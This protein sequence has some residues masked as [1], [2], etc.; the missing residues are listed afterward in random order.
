MKAEKKVSHSKEEDAILI[1]QLEGRPR[2]RTAVPL[3]LQ[4]VLAM[5]TGNLAPILIIASAC[6]L[7]DGDIVIMMQSAMFVSG[8]TTFVQLYPIRIGKHFRIG[9]NLPIV[10]GT[11][12]AFVPTATSVAA[13][14][15]I[16]AVLAGSIV[17]SL[18][19]VII[20]FF[21]KWVRHLFPPLVIGCTLVTIGIDLL[22]VGANY[23]A[24]GAGAADYGSPQNIAI[25]T[26][27]L[28]VIVLLQ[29]F[30]KGL[31]KSTSIL[32]GLIVGYLISLALN[33]VDVQSIAEASFFSV[34][35][36]LYFE[37]DFSVAAIV[38]FIPL[39]VFSGIDTIGST[40]GVAMA[41][42]D[43]EATA[44]E[45]SGAILADALG[46]T[47][48][49]I[50]NSLPNT[51]FGQNV[52]IITMTGVV[53]KFCIATG[54]MVLMICG[55]LPKLG[56]VFS[57]VPYCVLG[58]AVISVFGTIAIN[59]IKMLAR[60]G[61]SERNVLIMSVTFALG[62]GLSSMP[63]AVAQLPSVIQFFF[64]DPIAATCLISVVLNVAFPE[65]KS[66]QESGEKAS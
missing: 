51:A 58:G 44:E 19:E 14:G 63:E 29:R 41:A 35:R 61:F 12:F 37:L 33:M 2:L 39:Y 53:N 45:T 22:E 50:F 4:H 18:A 13:M 15:G 6:G 46:S 9:G 49:A 59:G 28:L 65:K 36:P 62:L 34:P 27:V 7:G 24:G 47:T 52:G 5:F 8:L 3:G 26:A 55:F 64:S 30:G 31:I 23:F 66:T 56:A 16:G 17:G 57:A 40:S 43:R 38:S 42:F 11:S 20:G 1:H 60:A 48:A 25:A 10:M 21:Y 54:A 32:I